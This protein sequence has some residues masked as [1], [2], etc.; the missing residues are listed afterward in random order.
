[1]TQTEGGFKSGSKSLGPH[2]EV[3]LVSDSLSGS[4]GNQLTNMSL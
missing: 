1:M 3:Y 2:K 4:L